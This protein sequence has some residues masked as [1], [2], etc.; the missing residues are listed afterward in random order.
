MTIVEISAIV[1]AGGS[2]VAAIMSVLSTIRGK[3]AIKKIEELHV[4]VNSRLSQLL[5]RTSVASHLQGVSDE[6][7]AEAKR[8][9]RDVT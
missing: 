4:I 2:T 3:T 7:D 6:R 9:G 5:D 8:Q 1:A